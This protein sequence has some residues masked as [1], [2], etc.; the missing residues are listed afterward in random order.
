MQ[1][2][3]YSF[4]GIINAPKGKSAMNY[5]EQ[6]LNECMND[7]LEDIVEVEKAAQSAAHTIANET[8]SGLD[9]ALNATDH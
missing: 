4:A 5:T 3:N 2:A 1:S 6:N 9:E 8:I 7:V